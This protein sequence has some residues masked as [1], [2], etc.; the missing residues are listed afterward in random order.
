M[1]KRVVALNGYKVLQAE[2][3]A[4]WTNERVEKAG[5]VRPGVYELFAAVS[6]DRST[7]AQG[8]LVI[9]E[10]GLLYQST[11]AGLVAHACADFASVPSPGATGTVA[12]DADSRASFE[13]TTTA[14]VAAPAKRR[15]RTE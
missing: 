11:A 1:R 7:P 13:A 12:Y 8:P 10:D 9:V 3:G 14:A 15:R 5:A 6:S 4:A 2:Q